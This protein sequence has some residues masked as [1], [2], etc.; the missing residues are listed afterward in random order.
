MQLASEVHRSA[1]TLV[2]K[3]HTAPFEP[4]VAD[5]LLDLLG[6]DDDYRALFQRDPRAALTQVGHELADGM[7]CFYEIT[8][9]SKEVI[10]ASRT[11]VR[12]MLLAGLSQETPKLDTGVRSASRL[13]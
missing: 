6:T 2:T 7:D 4:A 8:L 9:A 1:P 12:R 13:R 11:E 3:L 10:V 5:R